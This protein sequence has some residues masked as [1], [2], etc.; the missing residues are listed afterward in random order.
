MEKLIEELKNKTLE[1]L[2]L[3]Y[4]EPAEVKPDTPLFGDEG[5]LGLDSIDALEIVIM[6]E[7]DY[8]VRIDN[9]E[10]GRK[11]MVSFST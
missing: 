3:N 9:K 11:V 2:D 8:G 1:L 7:K 10:L 4:V 5:S 6:L